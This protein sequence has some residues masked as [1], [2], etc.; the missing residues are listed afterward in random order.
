[1]EQEHAPAVRN[2]DRFFLGLE[3]LYGGISEV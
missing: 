1:M 2:F 3:A